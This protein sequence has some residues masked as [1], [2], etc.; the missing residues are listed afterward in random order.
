M[1]KTARRL[2]VGDLIELDLDGIRVL[3]EVVRPSERV[4][5][6]LGVTTLWVRECGNDDLHLISCGPDFMFE[7]K[8]REAS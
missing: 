6:P 5:M 2:E 4:W 8:E 7:I 3:C 1:R